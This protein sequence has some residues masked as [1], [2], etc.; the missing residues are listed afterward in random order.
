[1]ALNEL[2]HKDFIK[3][4]RELEVL[5]N[6][7]SYHIDDIFEIYSYII[8]AENNIIS[9]NI[10]L[11]KF[12]L[13]KEYSPFLDKKYNDIVNSLLQI[14]DAIA[15]YKDICINPAKYGEMTKWFQILELFKYKLIDIVLIIYLY[16]NNLK[17]DSNLID[18][19]LNFIR[20]CFEKEIIYQYEYE[21]YELYSYDR[22]DYYNDINNLII[23]IIHDRKFISFIDD[24][25]LQ[26]GFSIEVELLLIFYLNPEQ[27]SIYPLN[28]KLEELKIFYNG[29][30]R[31]RLY[32]FL[33]NPNPIPL[34]KLSDE[35]INKAFK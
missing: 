30:S 15:L 4:W 3:K 26:L 6:K 13:E 33:R 34:E 28:E 29:I 9:Q 22:D 23:N 25:L 5:C 19:C 14:V 32:D 1:M 2:K 21:N 35:E 7:V 17:L 18:F 24:S 8:K 20:Y 31:N 11:R 16:K 10:D 12:F 27:N